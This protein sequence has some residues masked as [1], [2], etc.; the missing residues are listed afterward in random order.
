MIQRNNQLVIIDL[1]HF[2]CEYALPSI[3]VLSYGIKYSQET[4]VQQRQRTISLTTANLATALIQQCH[5]SSASTC[6]Q[7]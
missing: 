5:Q 7:N 6:Y 4:S 2:S 3:D 1:L